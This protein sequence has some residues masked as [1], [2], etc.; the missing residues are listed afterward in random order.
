MVA[1]RNNAALIA[2]I[3][4]DHFWVAYFDIV[5]WTEPTP[6][7]ALERNGYRMAMKSA[8]IFSAIELFLCLCGK[9]SLSVDD[10]AASVEMSL[11]V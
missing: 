9:N 2:M 10:K 1:A 11:P 6:E 7:V 5:G 4:E 8:T 3:E